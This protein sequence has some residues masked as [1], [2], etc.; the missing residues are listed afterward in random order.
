MLGMK[1]RW[2]R[3][4]DERKNDLSWETMCFAL[5]SR[6]ALND[7]EGSGGSFQSKLARERHNK[8]H[9]FSMSYIK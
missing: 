9:D 8:R 6:M 2:I 7:D 4:H 1:K 5:T 3:V